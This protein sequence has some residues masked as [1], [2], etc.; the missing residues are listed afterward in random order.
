[1]KDI[2]FNYYQV[3]VRT[4]ALVYKH[5]K[6]HY[7]FLNTMMILCP[8][9]ILT[10]II[11]SWFNAGYKMWLIVSCIT[12]LAMFSYSVFIFFKACKRVIRKRYKISI[13]KGSW[14]T[15]KFK[16]LKSNKLADFLYS[17]D[18]KTRWKI[19]KLI[20]LYKNDREKSKLP[21]LI[22]PSLFIAV[23]TPNLTQLLFYIYKDKELMQPFT[24][25]LLFVG[26][27]FLS[28]LL[29][30][31]STSLKRLKDSIVNEVYQNKNTIRE[32]L[33]DQLE[34]LLLRMSNEKE[35]EH[36]KDNLKLKEDTEYNVLRRKEM[37]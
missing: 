31:I 8:V 24:V 23:L 12:S 26:C 22:A 32:G 34:D 3:E 15:E 30:A 2:V 13:G 6:K 25:L 20:E 36:A 27:T 37:N 18:I 16:E 10:C 29:I 11:I 35:I 7:Y 21:P 4:Y 28:L 33:I 9:V 5:I 14:R 19:E 17:K 1:M